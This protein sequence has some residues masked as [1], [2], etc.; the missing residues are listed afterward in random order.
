MFEVD[1]SVVFI[2][3]YSISVKK[4]LKFVDGMEMVCTTCK[5]H[6][7]KLRLMPSATLTFVTGTF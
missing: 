1:Y 6:E 7:E 3:S 4:W 2:F 5:A